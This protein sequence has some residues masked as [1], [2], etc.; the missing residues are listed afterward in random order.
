MIKNLM[1]A[2]LVT[3]ATNVM[4][5]D[6]ASRD[7]G[8]LAA[9]GSGDVPRVIAMTS[10]DEQLGR[11][12]GGKPGDNSYDP[13]PKKSQ[14]TIPC[15]EIIPDKSE[16]LKQIKTYDKLGRVNT[17]H[18]KNKSEMDEGFKHDVEFFEA[19]EDTSETFQSA[20][21]TF[22]FVAPFV[23]FSV[24]WPWV[25]AIRFG[26]NNGFKTKIKNKLPCLISFIGSIHD[27]RQPLRL[28]FPIRQ[29][30]TTLYAVMSISRRK[31][32]C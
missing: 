1:A 5:S 25:E 6:A 22:N 23:N 15:H 12:D 19:R 13:F 21:Q 31:A 32:E 18:I 7:D 2:A 26:R 16:I 3:V 11:S 30:A 8:E 10:A 24:V 27:E 28:V 29:Q 9:G 20:E 14:G 17:N 4:A